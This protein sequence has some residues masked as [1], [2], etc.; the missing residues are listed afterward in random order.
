MVIT[1]LRPPGPRARE[2][3]YCECDFGIVGALDIPKVARRILPRLDR[4][5]ALRRSRREFTVPLSLQQAGDLL[6][7]SMRVRQLGQRGGRTVWETRPT[8]S[9]GGCHPVRVV[10]LGARFARDSL[11]VYD[12]QHHM[13]GVHPVGETKLMRRCIHEVDRCVRVGKGTVFWFVADMERTGAKYRNPESLVW[14]DSG[15]LFATVGLVAEALSLNCC[16]LGLHE[17]PSAREL[18]RLPPHVIGVGG[19]IVSGRS[20]L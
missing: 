20:S 12:A 18:L 7:H 17:I 1:E 4:V 8:P 3:L 6:W 19:C 5:L 15:A 9:A 16:G 11:L 2:Q 13:F 10:L 14:R